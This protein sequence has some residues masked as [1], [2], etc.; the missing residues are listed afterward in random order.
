V[1][2]THAKR[3]PISKPCCDELAMFKR[4]IC[5]ENVQ[6]E[7][8]LVFLARILPEY[9]CMRL[10]DRVIA[11]LSRKSSTLVHH[12]RLACQPFH[13]SI[14]GIA[15][16]RGHTHLPRARVATSPIW[17]AQSQ[18]PVAAPEVDNHH[19]Q[20][21]RMH[22]LRVALKK[23]TRVACDEESSA[24]AP[25]FHPPTP[26]VALALAPAGAATQASLQQLI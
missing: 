6:F 16:R 17:V 24:S 15:T 1:P 12:R 26:S 9:W 14:V 18:P 5:R 7:D 25:H 13:Q 19:P 10:R 2:M 23:S 3:H 8:A 20:H 4:S 11:A 21:S 22:Q